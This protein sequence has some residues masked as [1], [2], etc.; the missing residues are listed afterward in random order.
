MI[1]PAALPDKQ[2]NHR[3]NLASSVKHLTG[4]FIS[5]DMPGYAAVIRNPKI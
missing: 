5:Q 4:A 3:T 1:Q 2:G